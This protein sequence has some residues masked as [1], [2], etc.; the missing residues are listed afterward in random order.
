MVKFY[1]VGGKYDDLKSNYLEK[2]LISLTAKLNPKILFFPTAML[3]SDNTINHF[4]KT[5][6]NLLVDIKTIRLFK[7][8]YSL[9]E[10]D[11]FFKSSDII[12]FSGGNTNILVNKLKEVG[13]DKLLYKYID[14]DKIYAGIS[15]GV[16]LYT[17]SGMGDSY[18]YLDHGK[19]YNYKMVKGLSLLDIYI[20]P[21][22]QKNDLYIFNDEISD[23]TLAY[24]IEDDTALLIDNSNVSIY[25]ANKRHS[26]YE[27]R[28]GKMK[29]LYEDY[30]IHLLGP[31]NTY[32]YLAGLEYIK[33]MKLNNPIIYHSTI[34]KIIE[35][36]DESDLA[37]LPLENAL[38]GY[39]GETLD[40]LFENNLEIIYDFNVRISFSLASF[41]NLEKINKIYV[42]FKAKGQCLNYLESLGKKLI[43]TESNIESLN[44]LLENKANYAAIIPN[45]MIDKYDF[46]TVVTNVCD[47]TNNYTRF[48]VLRRKTKVINKLDK[49]NCSLLLIPTCDKTGLLYRMLKIFSDYKINLNSIMSRPT[50]EGLG[51]YY[52]Y[53]EFSDTKDNLDN[54]LRLIKETE[55]R[56]DFKIKNLGIYPKEGVD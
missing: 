41:T 14:S 11:T 4:I 52:F 19:V 3:D 16:I 13:I 48:V 8:E 33:K 32:S 53:V 22:Y 24:G 29:A 43:E 23:K 25:K 51:K 20:C 21:H 40:L 2:N 30:K 26:V 47:K 54:I 38:D 5:F 36:M 56:N 27:F 42:Q 17:K 9:E 46:K 49:F 28:Y 34:R 15:A 37:I 50:K 55:D 7:E 31:I 39:L 35:N 12:Y 6:D 44:L 45:H 1:L 10:L 18:S